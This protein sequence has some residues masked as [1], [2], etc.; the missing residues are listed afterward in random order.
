MFHFTCRDTIASHLSHLLLPQTSD[1]TLYENIPCHP[2]RFELRKK[3]EVLVFQAE[4]EEEKTSWTQDVWDL[5]FSHMLQLKGEEEGAFCFCIH[6]C[7][8]GSQLEDICTLG[9]RVAS[10]VCMSCGSVCFDWCLYHC[11]QIKP[12][13]HTV[14]LPSRVL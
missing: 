9:W 6:L 3:K 14:P 4:T 10:L 13:R 1:F 8:L 2:T 7:L 11:T 12:W 5:Y